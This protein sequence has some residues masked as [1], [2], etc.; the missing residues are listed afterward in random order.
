MGCFSLGSLVPRGTDAL[1]FS[2]ESTWALYTRVQLIWHS[3]VRQRGDLSLSSSEQAMY[4]MDTWLD[5]D[6]VEDLWIDIS[7]RQGQDS[8]RSCAKSYR[9]EFRCWLSV[10]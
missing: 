10:D 2:M 5:L 3:A 7:A 1:P 9:S 8:G 4:T 6:R